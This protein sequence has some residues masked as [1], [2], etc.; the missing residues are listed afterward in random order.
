MAHSEKQPVEKLHLQ[1]EGSRILG[2]SL[3]KDPEDPDALRRKFQGITNKIVEGV[4]GKPSH[5]QIQH[6]GKLYRVDFATDLPSFTAAKE[7]DD[8][9]FG[10][11]QGISIKELEDIS[12]NGGVLLLHDKQGQLV[13]ESQ[14]ITA[15]IED[16]PHL[17]EDE[18]YCYGT[19]IKQGEKGKDY[20]QVLFKAQEVIARSLLYKKIQALDPETGEQ[21]EIDEFNK[22]RMTLT[23]RA[24]NAQSLRARLKA[25][26]RIVG[27]N[28]NVY[29]SA[30]EGGARLLMEKPLISEPLP[31]DPMK[32]SERLRNGMT[33][34]VTHD[35]IGD[36]LE[37]NPVEIAIPVLSGNAVD[38]TAQQLAAEVL[39]HGYIGTGLLKP[40][41]WD[42]S[43]QSL[44]IFQKEDSD[45]FVEELTLPLQISNDYGKL[46][47]VVVSHSPVASSMNLYHKLINSVA[48]A[49]AKNYD[50][51]AAEEEYQ[52]FVAALEAAGIRIIRTSAQPIHEIA[53]TSIFTR[54]PG[55]V[56]DNQLI[57]GKMGAETRQYETKGMQK[58]AEGNNAVD[59][60]NLQDEAIIEGGD[61]MPLDPTFV[62]VGI[63][64]RTNEAGFEKLK[65][66]FPD[67][68]FIGIPHPDLH[69]DVVLTQVGKKTILAD[70]T[71][72]NKETLEWFAAHDYTIIKAD[73][74]EQDTLGTNVFTVDHNKV[75][76]VAENINTNARLR[77]AGVEVIEVSMPNIIKKGG[78]PRCVTCP[79]NRE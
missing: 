57:I 17:A 78:G 51:I 3:L 36:T 60:S 4:D 34:I 73:P 39:Q 41:E 44:F 69:L 37:Q 20:A 5:I 49:N 52:A 2:K 27:Y 79:T 30:I 38:L 61:I 19:A 63:G 54:D 32:Q 70:I 53:T 72:L 1:P 13:G 9:A 66:A 22:T 10:P 59:F 50:S 16:Y 74:E 58:I 45:P 15:P 31:F 26:F 21:K 75:I 7:L 40:E 68:V 28:E 33:P 77:E 23:V 11:H 18:V 62:L 71:K 29:G 12:K 24:E 65:T 64:E 25:G 48:R 47:E 67:K 14:V 42:Q 55:I 46:H 35:T 76:A 6:A 8:E 43:K 56:L